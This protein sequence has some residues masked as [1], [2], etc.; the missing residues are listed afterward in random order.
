MKL[1]LFCGGSVLRQR[2]C[3]LLLCIVFS[4]PT[5]VQGY[6]ALNIKSDYLLVINTYTSDAPW[7]NA[8]IEPVQKWVSAERDVTV[9]VE[10]LNM[11][12]VENAAELTMLK[13][14]LFGKYSEK[15]PKGVLL[16]GNSTILLKD[17]IRASWGDV[18]IV[19][20]AE[21]D[22]FGPDE[23]Y[24]FKRPIPEEERVSLS[25]LAD[26][27]NLTVLQTKMFPK[28][29]INLL[30][31]MIPSLKE[32]LLVGDGRYVNQQLDYDIRRLVAH[33]YPGLK[34]RFLSA[35]DMSLEQLLSLLEKIDPTQ[36]G[37]L[38]SSW[39][40]QSSLIGNPVL[41]ANSFRVI[42][43]L[44]VP[45]FALKSAVMNNSGMV[46]GCFYDDVIFET[47]LQQTIL[48][49]LSDSPPPGKFRFLFLRR[50]F[51]PL[52]TLRYC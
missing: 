29:N 33:E 37:V 49:V 21:Q 52:I 2:S 10:H 12:V 31:R 45:V 5:R 38:F 41:N 44:S 16:L 47:H 18:P 30:Q 48:S 7:S 13:D 1:K 14:S 19:M 43:N 9:F 15:P 27:Y 8:I 4:L 51:R 17:K 40:Q 32:V 3:L 25:T 34:Y 26:E 46:G 24:L 28:D 39:F 6:P 11:L 42:A 50:Q 36:T 22:Y 23:A 20:C 35:E